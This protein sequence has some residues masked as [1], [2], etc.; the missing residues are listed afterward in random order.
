MCVFISLLVSIHTFACVHTYIYSCLCMSVHMPMHMP[1]HMF[2]HASIHMSIPRLPRSAHP[3]LGHAHRDSADTSQLELPRS[4]GL[5]P[6]S[7]GSMKG[8][9]RIDN[10]LRAFRESRRSG[11][12]SNA[13]SDDRSGSDSRMGG[14]E[15]NADSD[16]R[17]GSDSS[18]FDCR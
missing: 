6:M 15:S 17:S 10:A 18:G 12:Q 16:D 4:A 14:W 13:D 9:D 5:W 7:S 1:M 3:R 8:Q 2:L 11:S